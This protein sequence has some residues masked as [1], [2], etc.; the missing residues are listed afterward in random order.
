MKVIELEQKYRRKVHF[1]EHKII[2]G[3]V[4][5]RHGRVLEFYMDRR[6]HSHDTRPC[7]KTVCFMKSDVVRYGH[8]SE[9]YIPGRYDF[10]E[11]LKRFDLIFCINFS[12]I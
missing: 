4:F 1:R 11:D 10:L 8:V 3:R 2:H 9:A 7:V 5:L 12:Y 6:R